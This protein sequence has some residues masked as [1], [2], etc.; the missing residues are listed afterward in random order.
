MLEENGDDEFPQT[1]FSLPF[2]YS[3]LSRKAFTQSILPRE[4]TAGCTINSMWATLC[5]LHLPSSPRT[6][7]STSSRPVPRSRPSQEWCKKSLNLSYIYID[8]THPTA[9][10]SCHQPFSFSA[11]SLRIFFWHLSFLYC[12]FER[13]MLPF[14]K[15]NASSH[16]VWTTHRSMKYYAIQNDE[17][18]LSI[19]K[20]FRI[21]KGI[22]QLFNK[23]DFL[24]YFL[25][26]CVQGL[27]WF[28]NPDNVV[29]HG[30]HHSFTILQD[31]N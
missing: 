10:T 4:T 26:L 15:F 29:R 22:G 31:I 14:S 8:S 13:G 1:F 28:V 6:D 2:W 17:M 3:P 20:Q 7:S 27:K 19:S 11:S 25:W 18:Q 12:S 21:L 24:I 5:V 9:V 16:R 30:I 23:F